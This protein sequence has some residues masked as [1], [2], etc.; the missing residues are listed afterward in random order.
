MF[1]LLFINMILEKKKLFPMDAKYFLLMRNEYEFI[2]K[3]HQKYRN[4]P[5]AITLMVEFPD[6]DVVE[7][8]ESIE[9]IIYKIKE[10]YTYSKV[11]K[12]LESSVEDIKNDSI[13]ASKNIREKLEEVLNEVVSIAREDLDIVRNA[14]SRGEL[15]NK[16]ISEGG[17]LGIGTGIKELD[18]IVHGWMAED[19]ITIF[20]R[21]NVGKSWI[22][23]YFGV[24]AWIQG[25]KVL[26]YS[27]EMS[28]DVVGYRFDT[29]YNHFSNRGLMQGRTKLGG[30]ED[31]NSYND[32][33]GKLSELSG[34][35]VVTP[36][37]LGEKPTVKMLETL[38]EEF[39]AD[40]VIVD[41][42]TLMIDQRNGENKRIRYT[43]IS[44]DLFLMSE[45]Y[46][47]PI[48]AVTQARRNSDKSKSAKELPPELD[49]IYESDGIAQNS[50]RVIS[51]TVVG[52]ILK[53]NVKKN[54]YGEKDK[55]V[56][57]IWD[58]DKGQL[59]PFIEE[60]ESSEQLE[61]EYNF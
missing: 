33:I 44:E 50:T 9:H 23:L 11:S 16:R 42:L 20:A 59:T 31:L 37:D 13:E 7:I 30:D 57:M 19:L 39:G 8:N 54:R 22:A 27:G 56:Y 10:A 2:L 60:D 14:V 28:R 4:V 51:M 36:R 48:I 58:I 18:E 49:E 47:I 55:E 15:Y 3:H 52:R 29:F 61:E 34:F 21:T 43:N 25:K 38:Q 26:M 17:L 12:V 6:F 53:L 41:Q 40:L 46:Q 5:D 1:E 45:K 35:D 24:M 32:Y